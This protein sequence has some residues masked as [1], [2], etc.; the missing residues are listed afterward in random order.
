[1]A[2]LAFGPSPRPRPKI[3]LPRAGKGL[4]WLSIDPDVCLG[5]RC[6]CSVREENN[7]DQLHLRGVM[8][9]IRCDGT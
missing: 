3:V 5:L 8:S 4:L 2:I 9:G 1:M 7:I 6:D